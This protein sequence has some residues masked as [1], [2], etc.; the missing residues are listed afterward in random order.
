MFRWAARFLLLVMLAPVYEP[1]AMACAVQPA[2]M[3]CERQSLSAHAQ[4]EMPCHHAEAQSRASESEVYYQ[5]ADNDCCQNHCCCGAT[6]SESAQPASNLLS[7]LSLLIE[8][9]QPVQSAALRSS[10]V[11]GR[12]SARAP[13]RS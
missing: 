11:S 8:P 9:A 1:A 5:A 3:H 2:A 7:C 13:P 12:D 6:T 4:P 10:D